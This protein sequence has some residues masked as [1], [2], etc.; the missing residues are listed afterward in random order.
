MRGRSIET[1]RYKVVHADKLTKAFLEEKYSKEGYSIY[2][3]SELV[4][5]SPKLV[6]N[7]LVMHQI[8]IVDKRAIGIGQRFHFLVIISE[9]GKTKNGTKKWLCKCD[10]GNETT[11]ITTMLKS[12]RT[13][14]CGCYKRRR[15]NHRWLG[16][17]EIS[18][19]R[20]AEIRL[21]ARKKNI[22][23]NLTAQSLWELW[24]AQQNKCKISGLDINLDINASVDRI[25]SN[26]GYTLDNV[27]W[28]HKDINKMK[29]D[30]NIEQFLQYCKIIVD[31]NR[32][33]V[34]ESNE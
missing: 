10:C 28:V 9:S 27:Q 11:T 12:G 6:Y 30:I 14:S 4:G 2:V 16:Y 21:R 15:K 23:F 31:F 32:K 34:C 18:G 33:E 26:D 8:P 3:I 19:N 1:G 13:K 20:M 25:D 7:Y 22:P 17:G 24:V 29:M 5:C